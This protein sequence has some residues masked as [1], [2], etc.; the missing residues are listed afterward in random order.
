MCQVVGWA[1]KDRKGK[2]G[3]HQDGCGTSFAGGIGPAVGVR[4][5]FRHLILHSDHHEENDRKDCGGSHEFDEGE[6]REKGGRNGR[7]KKQ[8]RAGRRCGGEWAT[9]WA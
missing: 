4:P 2:V 1:P 5:G 7:H 6:G 8:R 9:V 3:R